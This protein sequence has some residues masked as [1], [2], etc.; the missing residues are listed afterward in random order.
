VIFCLVA[1]KQL[2][3][4]DSEV[5]YNIRG[6]M[7]SYYCLKAERRLSPFSVLLFM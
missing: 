1:I 5:E 2:K 6:Y 4:V 7:I 3:P